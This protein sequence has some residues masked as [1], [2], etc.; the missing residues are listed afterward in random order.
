MKR[1]ILLCLVLLTSSAQADSL[2]TFKDGSAHVWASYYVKRNE[3]CTIKPF[4]EYCVGKN[5][6]VSIKTVLPGT[7]ASE[8][9][10]STLGDSD[11]EQQRDDNLN[12][13][14]SLKCS[15]L[16][17][18][19]SKTAQEAYRRECLSR[20]QQ[21]VWDEEEMRNEGLRRE[22]RAE[23][24][25]VRQEEEKKK[26]QSEQDRKMVPSRPRSTRD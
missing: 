19:T 3:Y 18:S 14:E 5:D 1:M 22:V 12:A 7:Q 15:Q 8:Y 2:F 16:R 26:R 9:G 4:G 17:A 10:I 25:R 24:E 21:E 13:L 11:L 23:E 6:V 20:E